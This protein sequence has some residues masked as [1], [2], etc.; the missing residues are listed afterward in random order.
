[1]AKTKE[2]AEAVRIVCVVSEDVKR[3]IRVAAAQAGMTMTE[4]VVQATLTKIRRRK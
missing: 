2:K 4:Y 1:M 3:E